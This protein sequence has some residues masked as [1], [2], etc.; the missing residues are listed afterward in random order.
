MVAISCILTL[1]NEKFPVNI[2][3]RKFVEGFYGVFALVEDVFDKPRP[4][5]LVHGAA[6]EDTATTLVPSNFL[7]TQIPPRTSPRIWQTWILQG[8]SEDP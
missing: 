1:L 7:Y 4:T 5:Q 8:T 2:Y 6:D 3:H